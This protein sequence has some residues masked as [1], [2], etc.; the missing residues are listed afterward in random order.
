MSTL[1]VNAISNV[2]GTG[3]PNIT[4][5]AKAWVNFNGMGTVAIRADFNV[6]SITDNG[7]GK[8]TV[9]FTTALADANYVV[10]FGVGGG[11]LG[12]NAS[13]VGGVL[14]TTQYGTAS[15]KTTTAL[16]FT[17]GDYTAALRDLGEIYVTIFR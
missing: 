9:N 14:T 17:T 3:S 11:G 16:Q 2:A 6:T 5:Q 4:E 13:F 12:L 1:K 10:N 7:T 15:N 8:Y